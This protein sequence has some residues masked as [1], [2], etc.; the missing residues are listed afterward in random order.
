[1]KDGIHGPSERLWPSNKQIFFI[2]LAGGMSLQSQVPTSTQLK[3]GESL[4]SRPSCVT[5][6]GKLCFD[7]QFCIYFH[8]LI[9]VSQSLRIFKNHSF[10]K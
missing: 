9:L 6:E 7:F 1:M 10:L 3:G 2:F 8:W 4:N 5:A